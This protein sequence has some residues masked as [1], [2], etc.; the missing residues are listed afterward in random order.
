[1]NDR[2]DANAKGYYSNR[3][4]MLNY[5]P[6]N[7]KVVLDIGW[8][9]GRYGHLVEKERTAEVWGVELDRAAAAKAGMVLDTI[10]VG[11][12]EENNL[13]MPNHYFDCIIFNDVL[14][15]LQ[16]PWL[17]LK[18][19]LRYLAINGYVV[20]SIPNVRFY[21]HMKKLL[22]H[23]EWEYVDMGIMDKTHLRFFTRKSIRNMFERCGYDVLYLEGING[24][25][26]PW[27]FGLLN[28]MVFN[29]LS[30]MRYPQYACVAQQRRVM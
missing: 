17:V 3:E 27:K 5:I 6:P 2:F 29:A 16:Y 21:D 10:L 11:N 24:D 8:G 22:L 30:D 20:A 26:F 7:V 9:E 28:K 12:I 25:K 13:L 15:H 1:M 14:E 4:E 19:V 23:E 18:K